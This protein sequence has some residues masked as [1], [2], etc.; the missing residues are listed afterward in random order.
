M[1][2]G[3]GSSLDWRKEQA[4][5]A[6]VLVAGEGALDRLPEKLPQPICEEKCEQVHEHVFKSYWDAGH[7]V[8]DLAAA[9]SSP[10]SNCPNPSRNSSL[11]MADSAPRVTP[12]Q[13]PPV[14]NTF[15]AYLSQLH[16]YDN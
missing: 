3:G 5:R 15:L 9:A 14:G 12:C 1:F 6:G 16:K 7:S 4:T 11:P 8:Y 13:L 2:A 10:A